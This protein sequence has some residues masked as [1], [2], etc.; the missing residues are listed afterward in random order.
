MFS[1]GQSGKLGQAL[2]LRKKK[3]PGVYSGAIN[4][5]ITVRGF[6]SHYYLCV[7]Q[8]NTIIKL[9]L[10]LYHFFFI[11]IAFAFNF[12]FNHS[13]CGAIDKAAAVS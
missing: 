5:I 10:T 12:C 4:K 2:Y 3:A 7:L 6:T 1:L 9:A 8:V 11:S 13:T